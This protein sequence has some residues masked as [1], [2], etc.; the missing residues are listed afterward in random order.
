MLRIRPYSKWVSNVMAVCLIRTYQPVSGQSTK[1]LSERNEF[2]M[3]NNT[4]FQTLD[5]VRSNWQ[6]NPKCLFDKSLKMELYWN[7]GDKPW[8]EMSNH[9]E[10]QLSCDTFEFSHTQNHFN[11]KNNEIMTIIKWHDRWRY[12]LCNPFAHRSQPM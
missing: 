7:F 10:N 8:P 12:R 11:N 4:K 2:T 5:L 6:F 9:T 1:L 3:K